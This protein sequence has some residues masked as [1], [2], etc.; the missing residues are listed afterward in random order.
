MGK[1]YDPE[2][3]QM[4]DQYDVYRKTVESRNKLSNEVKSGAIK[5]KSE[6]L[7][8]MTGEG[9]KPTAQNY[10][11]AAQGA[12]QAAQADNGLG[13][14]GGGMMAAGAIPSPASI[15]FVSVCR[16]IS[17]RESVNSSPS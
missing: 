10:A 2:S 15:V 16:S 13:A 14:L 6:P 8:P 9:Q 7:K 5:D 1:V 3:G 12:M 4:I 17:S 11:A